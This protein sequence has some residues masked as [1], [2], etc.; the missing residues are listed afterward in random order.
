MRNPFKVVLGVIVVVVGAG[1]L[2]G[3]CIQSSDPKGDVGKGRADG[4]AEQVIA[5]DN[6]FSPTELRLEA[7]R[8]V[9][10]EITNR[11]DT[12]HEFAVERFDLSTGTIESGK[13]AHATFVVPQ[14]TTPFVCNYHDGMRGLILGGTSES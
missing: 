8:E 11:G 12:P 13:S 2:L 10:V 14:G 4:L 1:L 7:G 9:T 3:S 6:T 5:A